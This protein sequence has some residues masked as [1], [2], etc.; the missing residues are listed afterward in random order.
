MEI[1]TSTHKIFL[2]VVCLLLSA[3]GVANAEA[4]TMPNPSAVFCQDRGYT[5]QIRT[6]ASGNQYGVCIFSEGVECDAWAFYRGECDPNLFLVEPLPT[7]PAMPS[8]TESAYQDG[9]YRLALS[10]PSTWTLDINTIGSGNGDGGQL[11]KLLVFKQGNWVFSL[12][13]KFSW[14][15]IVI[16]GGLGAGE[17]VEG[18]SIALLGTSVPVNKLT[19]Q[20]KTKL[21]WYGESFSDLE[22]YAKLEDSTPQ[23][24][25]LVDIDPAVQAEVEG[26]LSSLI[27]TGDP[28][29]VVTEEPMPTAAPLPTRPATCSLDAQLIVGSQAEV[30]PGFPNVVR[31]APGIGTNSAVK[32]ELP[33]GT[34]VDVLDGPVC[35]D[36]YYW[37]EVNTGDLRGW[38]AE[39]DGLTYW[40]LPYTASDGEEVDGWVGVVVSAADW[41]QIDDYFQMMDQNGNRFGID[42]LDPDL[43]LELATYRDTG[44][45]IRIWGIVYR[46]RMDAYNTQIEVTRIEEYE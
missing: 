14:D 25:A 5:H 36:G 45:M 12:H 24:Y 17:I 7:E 8:P 46:N 3:C 11:S 10:Y 23:D 40:L 27:R 28:F 39:G 18:G 16:G 15:K 32:G 29:P 19:Y 37:W 43:R 34:V 21:I 22:I 33:A 9:E 30:T 26:I 6:D 1:T 4:A 44:T 31:S 41:P 13:Y 35:A 42:S 20:G 2:V 38:T